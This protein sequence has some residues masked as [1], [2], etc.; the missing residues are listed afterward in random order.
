[1]QARHGLRSTLAPALRLVA[2]AVVLAIPTTASAQD[3]NFSF[4]VLDP[5]TGT[6]GYGFLTGTPTPWGSYTATTGTLFI[7]AGPATGNRHRR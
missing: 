6:F 2:L 4:S 1:M 7:V 3:A 5:G